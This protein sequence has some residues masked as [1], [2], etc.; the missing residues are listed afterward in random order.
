MKV[1]WQFLD[2]QFGYQP[3]V[4]LFIKVLF[5]LQLS[6]SSS[7]TYCELDAEREK[8]V[9]DTYPIKINFLNGYNLRKFCVAQFKISVPHG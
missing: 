2:F 8:H 1:K 4:K 7:W 9:T 5:M 3:F 6:F